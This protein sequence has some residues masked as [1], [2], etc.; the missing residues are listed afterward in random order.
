MLAS[1]F[2]AMQKTVKFSLL[3]CKQEDSDRVQTSTKAAH[4]PSIVVIIKLELDAKVLQ[5]ALLCSGGNF[6]QK[7]LDPDCGVNQHQNRMICS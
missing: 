7:F 6:V 3:H 5:L 2:S 1:L 4:L